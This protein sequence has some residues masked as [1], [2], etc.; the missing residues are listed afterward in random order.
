MLMVC[1][2]VSWSRSHSPSLS[3][4]LSSSWERPREV[5]EVLPG[6][7]PGWDDPDDLLRDTLLG[8]SFGICMS[9]LRPG[10]SGGSWGRREAPMGEASKRARAVSDT[11]REERN[12]RA[13]SRLA[14]RYDTSPW[15]SWSPNWSS[16]L[17]SR[18]GEGS[19][20]WHS[21]RAE[22]GT[23]RS[24]PTASLDPEA[25][26]ASLSSQRWARRS[27]SCI[28]LGP[29]QLLSHD[30]TRLDRRYATP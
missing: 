23:S 14:I 13:T 16:T 3:M 7:P 8:I 10:G 25:S 27:T 24:A 9:R 12:C 2:M 18:C 28:S 11:D 1:S 26:M 29:G 19:A 6:L 15:G 5:A 20:A 4:A 30:N 22:S 17:S 21:T